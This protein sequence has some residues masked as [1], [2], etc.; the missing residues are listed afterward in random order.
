MGLEYTDYTVIEF[1]EC[2]DICFTFTTPGEDC[3]FD[4][5]FSIKLSAFADSAG[6]GGM[7]NITAL[8]TRPFTAACS[9]LAAQPDED[10]VPVNETAGIVTFSRNDPTKC[11][12]VDIIDDYSVEKRESFS[13][14]LERTENLDERIRISPDRG[15]VTIED[16]DGEC[17][18]CN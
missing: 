4:Y 13:I 6:S 7:R 16:F 10:F 15:T 8:N 9:L 2:I 17:N 12:R 3:H 14:S 5:E 18:I 1:E 11:L